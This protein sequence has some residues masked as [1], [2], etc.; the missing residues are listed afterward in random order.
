MSG[1]FERI[2]DCVFGVFNFFESIRAGRGDDEVTVEY[3]RFRRAC[4]AS[5][6]WIAAMFAAAF[7]ANG[8][9]AREGRFIS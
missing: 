4:V 3:K 6:V 8:R 2:L 1:I 9:T 7:M 5:I